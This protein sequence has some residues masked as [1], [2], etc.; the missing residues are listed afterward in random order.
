MEW[1]KDMPKRGN[2]RLSMRTRSTGLSAIVLSVLL[3]TLVTADEQGRDRPI[4]RP[5][6]IFIMADD[7]GYGD[8]G[9]YGQKWIQTPNIDRMAS[10]GMRFTHCYAGAPVCAASRSALMT[11]QHTGH[12][13]VRD[14]SGRV[15]GVP[16]EMSRDGHRI[17]PLDE[18]V[19]VAEVMG[20]DDC[21][22]S[23]RSRIPPW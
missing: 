12:T 8:L 13:R 17:P 10:E 20:P 5:N 1:W 2:Y 21:C 23:Q 9:C 16:D 7:L 6:I 3:V 14:N 4:S 15:G 22:L 18:D 19:T 11:G